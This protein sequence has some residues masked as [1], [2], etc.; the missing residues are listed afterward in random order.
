MR[1]LALLFFSLASCTYSI[2]LIDSTGSASDMVDETAT[3]TADVSPTINLP[4]TVP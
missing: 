1:W 3:P 4:K 2:N